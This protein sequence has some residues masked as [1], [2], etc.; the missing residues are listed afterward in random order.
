M[1]VAAATKLCLAEDIL[2]IPI[3]RLSEDFRQRLQYDDGDVAVMRPGSRSATAVVNAMMQSLLQCFNEPMTIARAVAEFSKAEKVD[4][5]EVLEEALPVLQDMMVSGLLFAEGDKRSATLDASLKPGDKL[6]S[7]EIR[8][9]VHLAEDRELYQA[10]TDSGEQVAIKLSREN[11]RHMPSLLQ[12]EAEILSLLVDQGT[13]QLVEL[14]VFKKRPYL[15]IEWCPGIPVSMA[16]DELRAVDDAEARWKMH[17]L[18]SRIAERYASLEK[19]GVLHCDIHP[20]NLIVGADGDVTLID[21]GMSCLVSKDGSARLQFQGGASFFIDP[22]YARASLESTAPPTPTA[23]AEQ[24][25][26]GVLLYYLITGHEY[27]RFD[28][29]REAALRQIVEAP[30]QP[31]RTYDI[32]P[33][34]AMEDVLKR[35]LAKQPQDR[36]ETVAEFARVIAEIQLPP[37]RKSRTTGVPGELL[38]QGSRFIDDVVAEFGVTGEHFSKGLTVG[39]TASVMAGAAG[40]AYALYRIAMRRGDPELLPLAELWVQRA[41]AD[42][43]KHEAFFNDDLDINASVIGPVSPYHTQAGIHLV[44]ALIANASG[45]EGA[46]ESSL[47][48]FVTA[49]QAETDNLD[50][51]A[52]KLST[53]MGCMIAID[54]LP[55]ALVEKV[56][57]LHELGNR[58]LG[59][60]WKILEGHDAICDCR[61]IQYLGMAH[62]WA[63]F[64]Y[65]A[66]RWHEL[67]DFACSST[68]EDRLHQV[69][70]CGMEFGRGRRWPWVLGDNSLAIGSNF[71]PGWC[72]GSAGYVHL[73]TKAANLL[74]DG[75]YE[76]W[77]EMAAWSTWEEGA[78][79]PTICCGLAGRAYALLEFANQRG[80][81]EWL[82][83][84]ARLARSAIERYDRNGDQNDIRHESLFRGALGIAVLQ[85]DLADPTHACMP[86][87][88]REN[89]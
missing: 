21:F 24:Y 22:E 23:A 19:R 39:P 54:S 52:G 77:A 68:L 66:L 74:H 12:H 70:E 56:T 67:T 63:G 50:I 79:S 53:V 37:P 45:D 17:T 86:F 29:E 27:I 26:L 87:F 13:P 61:E 11:A 9:V 83:R 55:W 4:P 47:T 5:N 3:E 30:V 35:A 25:R 59:E 43:H 40:I 60:T 84:A 76:K 28:A 14:S 64:C 33:W 89:C 16:A 42:S 78:G 32:E 15:A 10:E 71:M 65:A 34:P 88:G 36:Y 20:N 57:G 7:Y 69:G 49:S 6:N 81:S 46:C 82:K 51:L 72:N 18:C 75:R 48:E 44:A 62:G 1:T 31:F 41:A 38:K 2:F 80:D 58:R 8:R 85:S 73:W